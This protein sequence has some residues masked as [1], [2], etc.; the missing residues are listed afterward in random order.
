MKQLLTSFLLL[1]VATA[2]FAFSE[3]PTVPHMNLGALSATPGAS[4][5]TP[6]SSVALETEHCSGSNNKAGCL[7]LGAEKEFD[8]M[9]SFSF[10]H[11]QTPHRSS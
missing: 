10:H 4:V 5:T 11:G 1:M 6:G 7:G 8:V 3:D 2:G 9:P